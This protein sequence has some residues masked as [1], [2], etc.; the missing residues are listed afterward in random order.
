MQLLPPYYILIKLVMIACLQQMA[1]LKKLK[2]AEL[3]EQLQ[4]HQKN[5]HDDLQ[6]QMALASLDEDLRIAQAVQQQEAK[7]EVSVY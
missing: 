3:Q 7:K 2:E 1:K 6:V 4:V 5:I